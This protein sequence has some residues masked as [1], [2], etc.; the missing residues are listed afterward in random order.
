MDKLT[1]WISSYMSDE[2]QNA[3]LVGD[4]KKII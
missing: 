1:Y 3:V 4:T 2:L